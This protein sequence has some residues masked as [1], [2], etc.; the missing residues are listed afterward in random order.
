M[1][2]L[3]PQ[4]RPLSHHLPALWGPRLGPQVASTQ[5]DSLPSHSPPDRPTVPPVGREQE[6]PQT[7]RVG[8]SVR[9][10]SIFLFL[11]I[12]TISRASVRA[13]P[14]SQWHLAHGQGRKPPKCPWTD[15]G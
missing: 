14:G 5:G 2:I 8:A 3:L 4:H 9:V 6:I 10:A 15:D 12:C 11:L 13:H 1:G 7:G